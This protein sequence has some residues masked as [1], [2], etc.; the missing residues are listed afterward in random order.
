MTLYLIGLGLYDEKDITLRGLEAAKK[1]DTIYLE[2]YTSIL[3]VEKEQLEDLFEK[4]IEIAERD[5]VE[6]RAEEKLVQPAKD[7]NV[8]L[9]VVGD[10][11]GATT[12]CDL[13]LRAKKA[14]VAV[15]VIHN[16]SIMN[17]IG[18]VGLELYKYG[19]TTSIPFWDEGFEPETPY[20]VIAMNQ[21]NGLHT[22]CLLDIKVKEP[23]KE[24]L[25]K[26]LVGNPEPRFMTVQQGIEILEKIEEKRQEK[27]ITDETVL[28]GVARI[29]QKDQTIIFGTKEELKKKEFGEP[30]HSLIV[31]G[32]L[33]EI[34]QEML[35]TL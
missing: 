24:E 12:H 2:H 20:D 7:K 22:L 15:E 10:P 5:L 33:H 32:A 18:V 31:V 1:C 19:K 17:A 35:D 21:K 29:G 27:V 23:T 14:D 3:G 13:I 8:A 26:G 9:L 16:A 4:K 30:L 25:R 11:L 34:E 6:S 28:V